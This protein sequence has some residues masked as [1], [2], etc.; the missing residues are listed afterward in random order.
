VATT[1]RLAGAA[2]WGLVLAAAAMGPW[3]LPAAALAGLG[4]VAAGGLARRRLGGVTGD[5]LG[6]AQ[7]LAEV[8]VL[9]LGAALAARGWTAWWR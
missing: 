3:V 4:T 5:V 2:G 8:G 6:A 7:Q 1:G 9:V